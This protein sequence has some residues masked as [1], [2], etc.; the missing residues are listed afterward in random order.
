MKTTE[1]VARLKERWK[2]FT[3]EVKKPA[4]CI[5]CAGVRI[6]WNGTR[7]RSAS[8][9]VEGVSVYLS[10]VLCRRVKCGTRECHKSWTL[11]PPGLFPQR[12]YQLCL[13]AAGL[14]DY[15]FNPASSLEK[16]AKACDCSMRTVGSWINWA[17]FVTDPQALERRILEALGHPVLAPLRGISN[18]FRRYCGQDHQ[19]EL[20]RAAHNLCL[21]EA[22]GQAHG[23]DP[24]GLRGV[25]TA[26][27]ANRYRLTTYRTPIIPDIAWRSWMET[28]PI[29]SS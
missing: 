17:A 16:V 10:D 12:H 14:S 5:F 13:T 23:C 3:R 25:L 28:W 27:V 11:R 21:L 20:S 2:K 24:P 22:L 8:I 1:S 15:L 18:R 4:R 26:V 9:L 19:K 29:M 6:W 7:Q